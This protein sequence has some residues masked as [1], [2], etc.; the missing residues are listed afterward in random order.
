[1]NKIYS[2]IYILSWLFSGLF[3]ILGK[4]GKIKIT[5]SCIFGVIFL[6]INMICRIIY[7]KNEGSIPILCDKFII[8][9]LVIIVLASVGFILYLKGI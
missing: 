9:D 7:D 6:F 1:M 2:L 3:F 4:Y 5:I 8:L